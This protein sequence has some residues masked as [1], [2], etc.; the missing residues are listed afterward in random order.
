MSAPVAVEPDA[1]VSHF[2]DT[3]LPL[4]RQEAMPV[5]RDR[6]LHGIV[7]LEDLKKLPRESWP[8][9][10]ISEVMRPVD[11]LLFVDA[12]TPLAR[13]E[14]MMSNNGAG[15]LAVVDQ[16]GEL[17]GFLRRGQLKRRPKS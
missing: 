16:A 5:A 12:A 8:R 15:A 6:R 9:T 13:A 4:H 3:V 1:L 11:P 14:T 10:R 7:T 17:V 2:I